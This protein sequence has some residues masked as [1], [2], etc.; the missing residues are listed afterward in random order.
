MVLEGH[1]ADTYQDMDRSVGSDVRHSLAGRRWIDAGGQASCE[2][3]ATTRDH[4]FRTAER[5][6]AMKGAPSEP[7]Q[8]LNRA[9]PIVGH[10]PHGM[11]PL[12][13]EGQ[14]ALGCPANVLVVHLIGPCVPTVVALDAQG[15]GVGEAGRHLP[16]HGLD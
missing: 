2:Y 7:D 6:Q 10:D 4:P 16:D 3:S 14:E 13:A 12:K 9:S 5:G 8:R 1:T 11:E 15:Y